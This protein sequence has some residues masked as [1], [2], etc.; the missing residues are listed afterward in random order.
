MNPSAAKKQPLTTVT[1]V[2]LLRPGL[3]RQTFLAAVC[4]GVLGASAVTAY[5]ADYAHTR[6]ALNGETDPLKKT[7]S[8]SLQSIGLSSA[9]TTTFYPQNFFFNPSAIYQVSATGVASGFNR[10]MR[11]PEGGLFTF[12]F[13]RNDNNAGG[14]IVFAG[15]TD[16]GR[17]LYLFG[18][19]KLR[20]VAL[21]GKSAAGDGTF[22]DS[23]V[24]EAFPGRPAL[25]ERDQVAFCATTSVSGQGIFL[26]TLNG[27]AV[28]MERIT[29][30]GDNSNDG[31]VFTAFGM[32]VTLSTP[33]VGSLAQVAFTAST[34]GSVGRGLY[35]GTK[36]GLSLVAA[37]DH[38]DFKM[39]NAGEIVFVDN[40]RIFLGTA[41]GASAIVS[42][43]DPA[44]GGGIF[45][46]P[47]APMNN[48]AGEVAFV[49]SVNGVRGLYLRTAANQFVLVA[50]TGSALD[51][52]TL[53]SLGTP[54]INNAGKV[55]FTAEINKGGNSFQ[56]VFVGDGTD[57]AKVIMVGDSLLDSLVVAESLIFSSVGP[58]PAIADF[59]VGHGSFNDRNQVSYR[60]L[61]A[62]GASGIFT[63]SLLSHWRDAGSGMWDVAA[64]WKFGFAPAA[65][66]DVV[67]DSATDAVIAGPVGNASVR[68]V[69]VGGGAGAAT[70]ELQ[71]GA[72]LAVT[73]GV[74]VVGNGVLTGVGAI[75]GNLTV[76]S[77]GRLTAVIGGRTRGMEYDWVKVKGVL[78][79]GGTC[80]VALANGFVPALGDSF[81]VLDFDATKRTGT[82]ASFVLPPLS[83][84]GLAWDVTSNPGSFYATGRI[85]VVPAPALV[86]EYRGLIRADVPVYATSG[87]LVLTMDANGTFWGTVSLGATTS[88]VS[89]AFDATG[90]FH[91]VLGHAGQTLDLQLDLANLSGHIAGTVR[92]AHGVVLADLVA[93]RAPVFAPAAPSPFKGAYTVTFPADPAHP[94]A[95]YP[96]GTGYGTLTVQTTGLASF[97]G[98]LGDTTPVSAGGRLTAGGEFRLHVPLYGAGRGGF[99]AGALVLH[100]PTANDA[101]DGALVWAKP[102]TP[103]KQWY[104]AAFSGVIAVEGSGFEAPP[105]H[106]KVLD[107]PTGGTFTVSGG[108]LAAIPVQNVTLDA[109][110]K[111]VFAAGSASRL[112]F[113]A[114]PAGGFLGNFPAIVKGQT[115]TFTAKGVVLQKQNRAAGLFKGLGATGTVELRAL[116][117]P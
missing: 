78:A 61:L 11:T 31:G 50:T 46:S 82:F 96:Q 40:N 3:P 8:T 70:L 36:S 52:G 14:Q 18:N 86:G 25:N 37:G 76:Q 105:A 113:V 13:S 91:G 45:S 63:S 60:A 48:D 99:L 108:G 73:N 90:V 102:V 103:T 110:N 89:G 115:Q 111:V 4:A 32:N 116:V 34:S 83:Q 10:G 97:V 68:S 43:G 15:D 72:T 84:P 16:H 38:A 17:N 55:M 74:N 56:G 19:N 81:D 53:K 20:T 71:P 58:R 1:A 107:F 69:Q 77:G 12:A 87:A 64:N 114:W 106:A 24:A 9:G 104:P 100:G 28:T 112:G 88:S 95:A 109:K 7:Y 93:D 117:A 21:R 59:T 94:E 51:G 92:D 65:G 6:I 44:P 5:G 39:N 85:A 35:V 80:E 75:G 101:V 54:E 2:K 42:P 22:V 62:T 66:R 30:L 33:A 98:V 49:A 27:T 79:C 23:R 57:L 41:A 26:A 29:R 67:I 47:S